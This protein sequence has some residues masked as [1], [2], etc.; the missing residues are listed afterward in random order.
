VKLAKQDGLVAL[1]QDHM[2][3]P[4]FQAEEMARDRLP[5][6]YMTGDEQARKRVGEL[7]QQAQLTEDALFA[8]GVAKAIETIER[9]DRLIETHEARRDL[10]LDQ[11]YK[12]RALFGV[13][14]RNAIKQIEGAE[15]RIAELGGEQSKAA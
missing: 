14:L 1:L 9:F 8:R 13:K 4:L 5:W 10:I 2:D 11:V 12:R 6:L 7:L 15:G 3:P